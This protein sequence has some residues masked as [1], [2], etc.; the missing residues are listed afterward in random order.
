MGVISVWIE[1]DLSAVACDLRAVRCDFSA[2]RWDFSDTRT[3][4]Q[5]NLIALHPDNLPA[6]SCILC[7]M[8][9][10]LAACMDA[11][12]ASLSNTP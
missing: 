7:S 1:C 4:M 11:G 12:R 10:M 8:A 9:G 5:Y 2:S 3:L 6:L